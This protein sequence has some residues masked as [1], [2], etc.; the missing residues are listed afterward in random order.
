M[1][2]DLLPSRSVTKS[3]REIIGPRTVVAKSR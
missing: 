2:Q 1:K 3:H